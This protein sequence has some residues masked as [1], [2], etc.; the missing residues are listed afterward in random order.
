MNRLKTACIAPSG[1]EQHRANDSDRPKSCLARL[2][3]P[4]AGS[5]N[6]SE[7]R[8]H[9]K[10]GIEAV[11]TSRQRPPR[12]F[13][14]SS[15]REIDELRKVCVV[16]KVMERLCRCRIRQDGE[17]GGRLAQGPSEPAMRLDSEMKWNGPARPKGKTQRK[18]PMLEGEL[19]PRKAPD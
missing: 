6:R 10:L 19:M 11:S 5:R 2:D 15:S 17:E 4:D 8:Q 7:R 1:Q 12:R 18:A 16:T 3:P 13:R 14:Y 9:L